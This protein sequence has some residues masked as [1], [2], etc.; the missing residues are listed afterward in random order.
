MHEVSPTWTSPSGQLELESP[1]PP[2]RWAQLSSP[3]RPR[4]RLDAIRPLLPPHVY[5]NGFRVHQHEQGFQKRQAPPC[6]ATSSLAASLA[7]VS[8]FPLASLQLSGAG[9]HQVANGRLHRLASRVPLHVHLKGPV[10]P[11]APT[12][13]N[14]YI[15]AELRDF[16]YTSTRPSSRSPPNFNA[17]G[18][19]RE[20]SRLREIDYFIQRLSQHPLSRPASR[21]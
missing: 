10:R 15:F 20:A 1:S 18:R 4:F 5:R 13:V 6:S 8:H 2:D 9:S 12:S 21:K 17:C 11:T 7:P 14:Y 19:L 3:C 16:G